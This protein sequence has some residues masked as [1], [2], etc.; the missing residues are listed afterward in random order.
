MTKDVEIVKI[1]TLHVLFV[2][3]HPY[4]LGLP[5]TTTHVVPH[6]YNIIFLRL[7]ISHVLSAQILLKIAINVI[8]FPNLLQI[9]SHVQNV[10][11][12]II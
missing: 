5:L 2:S 1:I 3:L 7:Q 8:L 12:Y 10:L 4:F 6:V 11:I 9:M